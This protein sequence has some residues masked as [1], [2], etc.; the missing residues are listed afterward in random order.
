MKRQLFTL[1]FLIAIAQPLFAQT[2]EDW[3]KKA[4]EKAN[5]K[6]YEGAIA[7]YDKA[8]QIDSKNQFSYGN[9]GEAK[10]EIGRYADAMN[11]LDQA[12][13]LNPNDTYAYVNRG[14]SEK[15]L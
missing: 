12:I 15:N 3:A 8:I 5:N 2:A 10:N 13:L 9:R 14:I 1:I 6:D 7:D 4:S 11:D